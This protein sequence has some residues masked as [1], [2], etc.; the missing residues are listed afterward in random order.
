MSDTV[1]T[2]II[3]LPVLL[4]SMSIHEMMHAFA[5]DWLGDDTARMMGRV[6]L[7]PVRHIDPFFTVALPLLLVLS[8]A[9][10]YLELLS[11]CR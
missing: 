4:I 7:N 9:I 2:L 1:L 10:I 11:R 8:A 3:V 5:S 6:S